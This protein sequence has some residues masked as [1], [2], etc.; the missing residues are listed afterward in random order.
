MKKLLFILL[1]IFSLSAH[2]QDCLTISKDDFTGVVT[3][4]TK[5]YEA[6]L[7]GS[8]LLKL[9]FNK[10]DTVYN[11]GVVYNSGERGYFVFKGSDLV[12][13]LGDDS[14]IILKSNFDFKTC[15]GNEGTVNQYYSLKAYYPIS[16]A[17]LIK[18]FKSGI[19]K[20]RIYYEDKFSDEAINEKT[21]ICELIN[22]ITTS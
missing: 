9:Y 4:K 16:E 15:I 20:L 13:L 11:L 17:D 8:T 19:S 6:D 10:I 1:F 7:S 2:S 3:K 22:C 21:K 14:K 12:L 18:I 5:S